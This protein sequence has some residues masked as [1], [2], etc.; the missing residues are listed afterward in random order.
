[1]LRQSHFIEVD[2]YLTFM[3]VMKAIVELWRKRIF[4]WL[5]NMS[6]SFDWGDGLCLSTM[7]YTDRPEYLRFE[8]DLIRRLRASLVRFIPSFIVCLF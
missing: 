2:H 5:R 3:M 4:G 6:F 8:K 7:I 1:M